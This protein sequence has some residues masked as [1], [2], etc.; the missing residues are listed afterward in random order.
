MGQRTAGSGDSRIEVFEV[1]GIRRVFEQ[2]M[3]QITFLGQLLLDPFFL[4]DFPKTP[5]KAHGLAARIEEQGLDDMEPMALTIGSDIDF[6]LLQSVAGA[7][8][9]AVILNVAAR[10]LLRKQIKV[11]DA[12]E[13]ALGAFDRSTE[14]PVHEG[15]AAVE[16]F[17]EDV[18]G[19]R[20]YQGLE[21]G[22]VVT[23]A[24]LRLAVLLGGGREVGGL[25][26]KL[27]MNRDLASD[28]LKAR[29]L[30]GIESSRR[31]IQQCD[32]AGQGARGE[33][34]RKT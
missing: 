17:T 33:S 20:F 14:G 29:P 22:L 5:L 18:L 12:D 28:R 4:G 10:Q 31:P 19:Q 13:L 15:E 23:Q 8:D 16:I 11:R 1:D 27:Q 34:Y 3:Q 7:N 21:V 24:C 2:R 26:P 25:S 9:Q 32:H 6:G 30:A